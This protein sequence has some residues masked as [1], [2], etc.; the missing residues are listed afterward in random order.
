MS[1]RYVIR[2]YEDRD[3]NGATSAGTV[4]KPV[5]M[6]LAIFAY[7]AEEAEAKL[8]EDVRTGKLAAGRVYQICPWICPWLN[9][10]ELIRSVAASLDG[11]FHR[12]FLDPASGVYG[13]LR[14]IRAAQPPV[15]AEEG[16]L[17]GP[18]T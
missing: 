11:T 4:V 9:S 2:I 16:V 14:R 8:R 1:H 13:E 15:S 6:D 17:H 10:P 12:V 7:T 18:E 5:T 3:Q